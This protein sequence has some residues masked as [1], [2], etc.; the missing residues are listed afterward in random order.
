MRMNPPSVIY[1]EYFSI[2]LQNIEHTAVFTEC[3]NL[4]KAAYKK[5]LE[6]D[7]YITF[8]KEKTCCADRRYCPVIIFKQSSGFNSKMF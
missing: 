5:R 2:R 1:L 3:K 4:V 6:A 8:E 7:V